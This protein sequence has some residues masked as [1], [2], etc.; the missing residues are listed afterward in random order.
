VIAAYAQSKND[1]NT[2][3]YEEKYGHLV[4][5]GMSTVSVADFVALLEGGRI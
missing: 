3:S 5:T 1:W 2:W 4:K